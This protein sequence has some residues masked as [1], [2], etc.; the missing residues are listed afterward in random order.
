[1]GKWKSANGPVMSSSFYNGEIYDA[2]LERTGWNL[3]DYDDSKWRSV[4]IINEE[5]KN[6]VAPV[7]NEIRKHEVFHPLKVI[8][9]PQ[10]DTVID[11]G[12]N[13]VGWVTLKVKGKRGH[14]IALNHAEV[15]DKN[16][17]FYTLNL[18]FAKQEVR[19]ILKDD[20]EVTLEPHF[21][22]QGFRYLKISGYPGKLDTSTIR[23]VA[24]YS[25]IKT[26]GSLVTS[27]PML[28]QLQHNIQWGQKGNFLD[29]PTD[30]P[31]RN[32]RLGWTGDAEVFCRTASY[33]MN[34]AG[35]FEKWM[36]DLAADQHEDGAV[37]WVIPNIMDKTSAGVAGWSDAA[38]V[39]P[40]NIYLTYG[41]KRILEQQYPSMKAWV[42]Y[43][44][45]QSHNYLWNTGF[46]FGDWCFYSPSPTDDSGKAAVTDKYLIAQ[47]FWANSTQLLINAAKVLGNDDDVKKY[48]QLLDEIKKAFYQEYVTRSGRVVSSTQTAYALTLA[49]DLL[50]QDQRAP[51]AARLV[52]NIKDYG[53]H[54]TTGFLG[55]PYLCHVLSRFGYDDMAYTLLLQNTYPSWLYPV[56]RGATTIWERWDGIKSNGDM[57][58]PSMN[59]FNHY[60]YGAIG[61]WMYRV[62][63]GLN[64]DETTNTGYKHIIIA[65]HIGGKLTMVNAQLETL[66]GTVQSKWQVKDNQFAID[67][68]I[69]PNTLAD[70]IL[71]KAADT[72]VN[73][74]AG[75]INIAKTLKSIHKEG[76]DTK[77]TVGSGT[78]HFQY[79]YA[80]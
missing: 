3:S 70:I 28:N 38:T 37:P 19:Y 5:Y 25:D 26:T 20:K 44:T 23:A 62:M 7:I 79:T 48:T 21:T 18:R 47:A 73:D 29:V 40:W 12:Q 11:F 13:L 68:V 61:D 54:L 27:N 46:H 30:C 53:N 63:A 66:Y 6:L 59:S 56:T 31:Q 33:N 72:E 36:K 1:D 55:T 42:D 57:Q 77:I 67:V 45:K 2:R 60:S 14:L 49:F 78:Y 16:G 34:V 32:E 41:D 58:D 8:I 22:Y 80:N 24:M 50:P 39:I 75:P 43:M 71:P 9:T 64:T 51:L 10:K 15:L 35:F 4:G 69:P 17:N 76:K 74:N 52:Q 65:P